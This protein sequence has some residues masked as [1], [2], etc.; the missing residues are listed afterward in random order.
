[1]FDFR[2]FA[3]FQKQDDAIRFEPTINN[4]KKCD[5]FY[6]LIIKIDQSLNAV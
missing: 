5:S 2:E 6:N 4:L 3:D 1:M